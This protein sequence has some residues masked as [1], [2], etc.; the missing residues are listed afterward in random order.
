MSA[1]RMRD[2]KAISATRLEKRRAGSFCEQMGAD[3]A[4]GIAVVAPAEW[5]FIG[6]GRSGRIRM[7]F[8]RG[9]P[10]GQTTFFLKAGWINLPFWTQTWK[11]VKCFP[12][13]ATTI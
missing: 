11:F 13:S 4:Q 10:R 8:T 6:Y 2:K 1:L 5:V 9:R 3:R 7:N 12:D